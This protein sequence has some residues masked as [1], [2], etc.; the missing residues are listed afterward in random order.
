MQNWLLFSVLL[1]SQIKLPI[2]ISEQGMEI[3]D[4]QLLKEKQYH[5][6]VH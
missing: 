2:Y 4:I 1:S 3:P 5:C 6:P